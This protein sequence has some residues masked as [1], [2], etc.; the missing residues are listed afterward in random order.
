MSKANI[1]SEESKRDGCK[2]SKVLIVDDE[3]YSIMAMEA[4]LDQYGIRNVE[5]SYNVAD[6]LEKIN[7]NLAEVEVKLQTCGAEH[8][9][10][11]LVII[12]KNISNESGIE[13]AK[14]IRNMQRSDE[15]IKESIDEDT[16][17]TNAEKIHLALYTGKETPLNA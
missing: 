10:Y 11:Q 1:H 6:A 7:C 9:P 5:K 12:D 2:C 13:L 3:P 4:Q 17:R 16:W 8:M 14:T 15:E